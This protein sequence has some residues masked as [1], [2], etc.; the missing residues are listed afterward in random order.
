MRPVAHARQHVN[1]QRPVD[2]VPHAVH[3]GVQEE[4]PALPVDEQR[5][6][7][8]GRELVVPE[9]DRLRLLGRG[10]RRPVRPVE[11][12]HRIGV[13]TGGGL[14][15]QL[16]EVRGLVRVARRRADPG[17]E[18][19][20][21]LGIHLH[22]PLEQV[23]L[24]LRGV[25][26]QLPQQP[27]GVHRAQRDQALRLLGP[28]HREVPGVEP[29]AVL[30]QNR[31]LVLAEMLDE[32]ADVLRDAL[33]GVALIPRRLVA[34]VGAA[35]GHGHDAVLLGQHRNLMP[36]VVPRRGDA[37]HQDHQRSLAGGVVH[38]PDPV[39]VDRPLAGDDRLAP[40]VGDP[41]RGRADAR[42]LRQPHQAEV[43]VRLAVDRDLLV[44]AVALGRD[45]VRAAP[46]RVGRGVVL[47]LGRLPERAVVPAEVA[48]DRT[49]LQQRE[50]R[51]VDDVADEVLATQAVLVEDHPLA[52]DRRP[53][54]ALQVD[55]DLQEAAVDVRDPF[56]ARQRPRRKQPHVVGRGPFDLPHAE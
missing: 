26:H 49:R 25:V 50:P 13:E 44:D 52:G 8:D 28:R 17:A 5:G 21:R 16:G 41:H 7:R 46:Q 9:P 56:D 2:P 24:L 4:R 18:V 23:R 53:V 45:E 54:P 20:A 38:D 11:A 15:A 29:A 47:E 27:R 33:R 10:R 32:G 14:L 42:L 31:R 40:P 37:V 36:V 48:A 39:R 55:L 6:R 19:L 43:R 35:S 3:R 22:V 30:P 34:H 12:D 1:R 51:V